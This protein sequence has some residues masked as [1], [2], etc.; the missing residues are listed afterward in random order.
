MA[1]GQWGIAG[2]ALAAAIMV[3]ASSATLGAGGQ[4]APYKAPRTHDGR[5]NFTGIWQALNTANWD[6]E[7]HG[8]EQG[9]KQFG[10]LFSIP[11]GMGVVEGGE[12]PYKPETRQKRQENRQK[13]WTDDPEVKCYLPGVPR[14]VY[15][16][17]PFQIVQSADYII[18]SSEYA[19]AAR[20]VHLTTHREA[21][22]DSWMGHSL[23]RFDGESLVVDVASLNGEAW[24][25]RAGNFASSNVRIVERFTFTGPDRLAYEA[26]IEDP[27]VF[28]RPWTIRMPLYRRAEP[29]AQLL[30]F[31]CVEFAEEVIYGHLRRKPSSK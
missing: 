16:P 4:A 15:M 13:R 31:K 6:I 21:P 1:R 28:T 22:V 26:R 23:G 8:A 29:D 14:F 17:Y 24:F 11:P 9:P 12:I 2:A 27:D 20:T 5:P 7:P 10:A 30:E 18:M 3:C 25:D 19:A